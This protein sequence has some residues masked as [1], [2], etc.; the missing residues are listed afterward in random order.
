MSRAV[1]SFVICV[2]F[3]PHDRPPCHLPCGK[4]AVENRTALAVVICL[5]FHIANDRRVIRNVENSSHE[6]LHRQLSNVLCHI[7]IGRRSIRDVNKM[8]NYERSCIGCCH[9]YPLSISR[10]TVV[11]FPMSTLSNYEQLQRHL[12]YVPMLHIASDRRVICDLEKGLL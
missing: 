10:L 11:S 9:M 6:Q 7:V 2:H 1:F 12:S 8:N 4:R 5:H 3:P